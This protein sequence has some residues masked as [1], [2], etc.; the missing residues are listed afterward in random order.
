MQTGAITSYID[1]AQLALYAF[2]LF[3]AGL[4]IYLHRE[5]KREGYPLLSDRGGRDKV[6]GFLSAVPP[7]KAYLMA[8]GTTVMVPRE[9][10][11][12][13]V[14]AVPTAIWPGAPIQPVGNAMRD[15]IGPAAY[16]LTRT[17]TPDHT[18]DDNLPKIV[19]LRSAP[20]FFLAWEDPDLRGWSVVGADDVEAGTVIEAWFDRS[21]VVVRYLEVELTAAL[22][23]KRVLLPMNYLQIRKKQRQIKTDFITAAQFADVP[24][25][26]DPDTVTLLEE[27]KITA[28]YAGGMLYATPG[29]LGPLL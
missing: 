16:A 9:E 14:N 8:D 21:E 25:L 7:P 28:Y 3:F 10:P 26:K 5:N 12:E 27:D 15:G 24:A 18:F 1:V 4:I 22:G 11:R 23:G 20:E 29:R 13:V 2:W 19:P 6:E 17:D